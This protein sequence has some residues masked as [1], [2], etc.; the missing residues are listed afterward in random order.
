MVQGFIN[1]VNTS[2]IEASKSLEDVV[3]G[4]SDQL[5]KA[6]ISMNQAE[7]SFRYMMEVRSR[8]VQAYQVIQRMQL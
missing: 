6:V 5:H 3:T 7:M 8:V 1:D 2:H 4:K